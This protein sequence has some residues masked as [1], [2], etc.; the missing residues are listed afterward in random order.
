MLS[1]CENISQKTGFLEFLSLTSSIINC[2]TANFHCL[3]V[4]VVDA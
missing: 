2:Q 1:C 3:A 4:Y